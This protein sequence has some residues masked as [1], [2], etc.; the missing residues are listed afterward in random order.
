[1]SKMTEK[2]SKSMLNGVGI[3][4]GTVMKPLVKS[5][6]GKAFLNMVPGEILLASLDAVSKFKCLYPKS[7]NLDD[8]NH[9]IYILTNITYLSP[10]RQLQTRFLMQ[11]KLL[12]N[13]LFLPPPVLQLEWSQTGTDLQIQSNGMQLLFCT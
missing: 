11:L 1:M 7:L 13:K 9:L 10:S 6:A 3:A 2:I 4:T 12:R 5:Q 8:F